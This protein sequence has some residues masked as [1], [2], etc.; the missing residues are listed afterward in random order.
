M[1]LILAG[2]ALCLGVVAYIV[3]SGQQIR[4]EREAIAAIAVL[5]FENLGSP[6]DD[7]FA[8]G[9]ADEVRAKLTALPSLVLLIWLQRRGHFDKLVKPTRIVMD[10]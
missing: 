6:E 3:S 7:Y 9:I 10:D 4:R 5:P 8:D 2:G 1:T